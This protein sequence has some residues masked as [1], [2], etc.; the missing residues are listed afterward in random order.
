MSRFFCERC[1]EFWPE[2][3]ES[4]V[5]GL[6]TAC[7]DEPDE[8]PEDD[9]FEEH[10]EYDEDDEDFDDPFAWSQGRHHARRA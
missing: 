1:D 3:Y 9:D 6:C 5:D 2:E 8:E 4:E 7:A 10:D